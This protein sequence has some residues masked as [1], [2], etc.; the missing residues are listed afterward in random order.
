MKRNWTQIIVALL[1]VVTVLTLFLASPRFAKGAVIGEP[2]P[3]GQGPTKEPKDSKTI[4]DVIAAVSTAAAAWFA[5]IA[6]RQTRSPSIP[7][8]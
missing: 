5:F 1:G 4:W 2:Q 3:T 7:S 8:G 6:T